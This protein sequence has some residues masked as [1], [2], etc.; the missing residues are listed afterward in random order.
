MF[1][2]FALENNSKNILCFGGKNIYLKKCAFV[3]NVPTN[4]FKLMRMSNNRVVGWINITV[5]LY[6]GILETVW[7]LSLRKAS[8]KMPRNFLS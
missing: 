4:N 7:D 6:N 8:G 3:F 5:G 1:L 2:S